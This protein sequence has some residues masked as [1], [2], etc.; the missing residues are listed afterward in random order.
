M[1]FL[2]NPYYLY[3]NASMTSMPWGTPTVNNPFAYTYPK[4]L[5]KVIH[6]LKLI[7]KAKDKD[8]P[9]G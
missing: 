7:L 9:L 5:A 1:Y 8:L 6:G 2:P 4:I 3:G